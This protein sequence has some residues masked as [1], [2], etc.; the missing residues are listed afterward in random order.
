M[1]GRFRRWLKVRRPVFSA[2][3]HRKAKERAAELLGHT[4][5]SRD[6]AA[7]SSQRARKAAAGCQPG[8]A[9]KQRAAAEEFGRWG[10]GY[11]DAAKGYNALAESKKPWGLLL[12]EAIFGKR[13]K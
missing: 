6:L 9:A 11:G 5:T 3:A 13:K 12:W 10:A 1:P 8:E 2:L 7:D 4:R